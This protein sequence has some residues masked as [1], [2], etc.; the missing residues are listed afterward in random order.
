MCIFT[1]EFLAFLELKQD[2]FY[3]KIP[4]ERIPYYVH[5]SLKIGRIY[6]QNLPN[7]NIKQLYKTV[8]IKIKEE[9]NDGKFFKIEMRAQFEVDKKGNYIV[10]VYKSSIDKLAKANNLSF[11]KMKN[12]VL[13]HEYFHY[14]E[15]KMNQHVFDELESVETFKLSK[16]IRTAK[17]RRTSEIAANVFAKEVANLKYLPSYFDYQYLIKEKKMSL[18]D[19]QDDYQE[20]LKIFNK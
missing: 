7:K 16:L 15:E 6:A 3:H 13:T 18:L 2:M 19:I 9:D 14:L 5:Q 11:E 17:I 20:Y 10:Y 1:D 8:D 12:I 4:Q